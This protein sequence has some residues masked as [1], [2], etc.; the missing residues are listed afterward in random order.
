MTHCVLK[1]TFGFSFMAENLICL[2]VEIML[3]C[4]VMTLQ[5]WYRSVYMIKQFVDYLEISPP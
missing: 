1:C 2:G 3:V 4:D 5:L